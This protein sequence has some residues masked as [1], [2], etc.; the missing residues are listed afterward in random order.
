MSAATVIVDETP[1]PPPVPIDR[2]LGERDRSGKG[3]ASTPKVRAP[4]G[5][6]EEQRGLVSA[7]DDVGRLLE[8]LAAD[9]GSGR[10]VGASGS[11]DLRAILHHRSQERSQ[12]KESKDEKRKARKK[13]KRSKKRRSRRGRSSSSSSETSISSDS[14]D[15]RRARG[16][17]GGSS[18][19]STARQSPGQL[20]ES[21]ISQMRDYLT[22]RVGAPLDEETARSV[23][24]PYLTSVL[25][26]S[27]SNPSLRNTRELQTLAMGLDALMEGRLAEA[28]DIFAQRF[29]AVETATQDGNWD[30]G[31]HFE[32]IPEA[33]V[34]T[35]TKR[36]RDKAVADERADV[37]SRRTG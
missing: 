14:S 30:V 11:K 29:K 10:S 12:E 22:G 5:P 31:K 1:V 34:S 18:I 27:L 26:P 7:L 20:A 37:R 33:R 23:F 35:V 13:M 17:H 25:L 15:F 36:E 32:M 21:C 4:E 28:A 2:A 6:S 8:E 9:G 16:R 24:G 19:L 3:F